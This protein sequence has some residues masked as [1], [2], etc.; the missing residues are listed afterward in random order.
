[1]ILVLIGPMGCGKTT[2]GKPP[3]QKPGWLFEDADDFHPAENVARHVR[4]NLFERHIK[5]LFL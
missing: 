2:T 5:P 1:M 4:G 3:A